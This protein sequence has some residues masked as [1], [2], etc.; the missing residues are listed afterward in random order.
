MP[1]PVPYAPPAASG[2]AALRSQVIEDHHLQR[3]AYSRELCGKRR[4]LYDI[5]PAAIADGDIHDGED[6]IAIWCEGRAI[7]VFGSPSEIVI[8]RELDDG[9]DLDHL[10]EA[11]TEL[12]E[13]VAG[14]SGMRCWFDKNDGWRPCWS[15]RRCTEYEFFLYESPEGGFCRG[16]TDVERRA[17][18]FE[19]LEDDPTAHEALC[20]GLIPERGIG[21]RWIFVPPPHPSLDGWSECLRS[22]LTP[23]ELEEEQELA[24][25]VDRICGRERQ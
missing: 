8:V 21:G 5:I 24:R 18:M 9:D 25:L 19:S 20:A 17:S 3:G 12:R 7:V 11:I 23:E 13:R 4:A 14:Q 1:S 16:A 15:V 6:G 10:I 22:K 2:V